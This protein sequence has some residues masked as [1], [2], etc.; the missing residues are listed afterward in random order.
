[1]STT[2]QTSTAASRN[3]QDLFR[4]AVPGLRANAAFSDSE[5]LTVRDRR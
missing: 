4:E 3:G 1:V 5:A 2:S